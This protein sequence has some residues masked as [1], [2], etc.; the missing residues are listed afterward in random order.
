MAKEP[1]YLVLAKDLRQQILGG[2]F[3]DGRQLPTESELADSYHVSR[4]TVRRAFQ[5][6]VADGMVFR[7]RGRGTF[8]NNPNDG[9]VRQVGSVDDLIGL[10]DDTAMKVVKP[11][12]R[13]VDLVSASR[14]RLSSDVVYE[15][16]FVR[17]HGD[18]QF[19]I[20]TVYV[21]THVADLLANVEELHTAG[22]ISPLTVLGLLDA[23]LNS[24]ITEAQ[25]SITVG[26]LSV[27]EAEHLGVEQGRPTLRIDRLYLDAFGNGTELAISQFLP[28]HYSYRISLLRNA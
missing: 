18:V 20:T 3:S 1:S 11:L 25:Q 26:T 13:K 12:S 27:E 16:Q 24:P 14:L 19:C 22:S 15:M 9:Y 6:L 23:R 28:E 10:S 2:E 4:Q 5:D 8:A 7:I 21:P 17:L